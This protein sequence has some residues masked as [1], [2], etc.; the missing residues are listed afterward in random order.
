MLTEGIEA[1][2]LSGQKQAK[3]IV[4]LLADNLEESTP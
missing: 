4:E 3:D 1:R 2:G